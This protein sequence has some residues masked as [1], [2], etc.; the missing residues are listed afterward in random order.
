MNLLR[1]ALLLLLAWLLACPA[2]ALPA[3][4][5]TNGEW[6]PYLS[7]RLPYYGVASR[8][9]SEAFALQGIEVE[10]GFFPWRRSLALA[11]SGEW[12]GSAIW[13]KNEERERDFY[14]SDPI[15]RAEYLF[16]HLRTTPFSWADIVDLGRYRIG[17]SNDYYYGAAFHDA[18]R[19]DMLT[20]EGVT[21]DEQ[22][23]RKL[24]GQ[25]IDIFPMD[26]IAGRAMLRQRFSAEEADRITAHPKPLYSE[27]MHLLLSKKVPG[28]RQL[29]QEFN[30][31][32]QKLKA[33]GRLDAYLRDVASQ[34]PPAAPAR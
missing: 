2:Q 18:I 24:L 33:S 22:N 15:L 6:P 7:Q 1:R 4:R 34:A 31:G 5:I 26:G 21:S 11:K 28:N 10:Y 16:F 9:V 12:N 3:V 27:T 14:I 30:Q 8:I 32:L 29:M 13:L 17:I 23:F 20:V 25:R 19:K